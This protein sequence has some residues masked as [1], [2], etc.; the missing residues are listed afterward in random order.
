MKEVRYSAMCASK[1]RSLHTE[2][3]AEKKLLQQDH[4][5]YFL[6]T[7][8]PVKLGGSKEE[9]DRSEVMEMANS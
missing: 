6:I 7:R 2:E 3:A 8:R 1:Q 9:L 4:A 5:W